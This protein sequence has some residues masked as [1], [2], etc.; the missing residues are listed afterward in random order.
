[1]IEGNVLV[2]GVHARCL[3]DS[4]SSHSF[5]SPYFASKL[6]VNRIVMD[7]I[8]SIETEWMHKDCM[9]QMSDRTLQANIILLNMSDFDVILG[10]DWLSTYHASINCFCKA[11]GRIEV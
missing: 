3:F 6:S 7:I 4:S 11:T 2:Y 5:I 10:M 1:M 8:L 9:I